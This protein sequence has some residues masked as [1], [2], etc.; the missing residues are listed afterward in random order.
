MALL[1]LLLPAR[2]AFPPPPHLTC[3]LAPLHPLQ[4]LDLNYNLGAMERVQGGF[5]TA[6]VQDDF[7]GRH[8]PAAYPA[9]PPP[10]KSLRCARAS[11]CVASVALCVSQ[12]V[13]YVV[14]GTCKWRYPP[15]PWG[16]LHRVQVPSSTWTPA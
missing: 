10:R 8:P 9:P 13:V 7:G 2:L 16:V 6:A 15:P 11:L 5:F 1:E 14:A 3:A 12:A 4:L